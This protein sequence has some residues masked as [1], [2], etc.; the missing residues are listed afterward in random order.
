MLRFPEQYVAHCQRLVVLSDTDGERAWLAGLHD[1]YHPR[2]RS[3]IQRRQ[4]WHGREHVHQV[5][6]TLAAESVARLVM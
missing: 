4:R 2:R 3:Y 6:C 5:L 1:L